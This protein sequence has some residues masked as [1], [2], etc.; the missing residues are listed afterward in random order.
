MSDIDKNI[1]FFFE[2][3]NKWIEGRKKYSNLYL[4]RRD[5]YQ[6]FGFNPTSGNKIDYSVL[7]PG[8][9]SVLAGIDLLSKYYY[10]QDDLG[11][12]GDR[13]RGYIKEYFSINEDDAKI[14]YQ[15]RNSLLHSFGLYSY[16][17]IDKKRMGFFF[18]VYENGGKLVSKIKENSYGI[19]II[20]LWKVFEK[21]IL[22]YYCDLRNDDKLKKNFGK[23]FPF[24]SIT[25]IG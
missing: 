3:P 24:Y 23:M 15:L 21:S 10:G 12:V 16:K 2:S 9:M 14:I 11:C 8:T 13:F 4:L 22:L 18:A 6:C 5:I 19:D 1:D 7:W 20:T 17:I 25:I